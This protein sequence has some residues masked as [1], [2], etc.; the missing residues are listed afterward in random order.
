MTHPRPGCRCACSPAKSGSLGS[1]SWLIKIANKQKGAQHASIR[2]ETPVQY[3]EPSA[4]T[5]ISEVPLF[6]YTRVATTKTATTT[7]PGRYGLADCTAPQHTVE[8]A[9]T[10]GP[11]RTASRPAR[12]SAV[13]AD[14]AR[15]RRGLQ[16]RCAPSQM[17]CP[18]AGW[19]AQSKCHRQTALY[20]SL[21][22]LV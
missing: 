10:G 11:P 16:P 4:E 20:F 17:A 9:C 3:D 14:V 7:T 22:N 15:R 18:C 12:R 1:Q 19:P 13:R 21:R 5:H 6:M 2:A 8:L